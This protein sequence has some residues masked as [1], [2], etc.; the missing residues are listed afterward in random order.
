V[1][2]ILARWVTL[3]ATV[4]AIGAVA[5]LVLLLP[6]VRAQTSWVAAAH[7]SVTALG[8]GAAIAL[9]PAA[10]VRLT[11][12]ALALDA[13]SAVDAW[14]QAPALLLHTTWG[15][16]FLCHLGAAT[17]MA[18]ACLAARRRVP[19]RLSTALL[20]IAAVALSVTPALQG[21]AVATEERT[22]L[23]ILADSAHVFGAGVWIG[24]IAV[25]GWL[26]LALRRADGSLVTESVFVADERLRTL[27]PLVPPIAL[28]GAALLLSSGIASSLLHLRGIADLV[29]SDWGRYVLIKGGLLIVVMAL[30]A[31]N[32]RRYGTALTT[33]A[34]P[35]RLRR[36]LAIELAAA[37]L[38]LVVTTVLIV[39]P[40][41]GE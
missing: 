32:W 36:A 39:T 21:H 35:P 26:G 18:V 14:K 37:A 19:A 25:V 7:H 20:V 22:L 16:G 2:W 31:L 38:A 6:R 30:G 41:P 23:A 10:L 34:G 27:V 33:A 28:T 24:G 11:D 9:V 8:L 1:E 3:T 4:L 13:T 29:E 15:T 5:V 12:Q 17:M 40:P